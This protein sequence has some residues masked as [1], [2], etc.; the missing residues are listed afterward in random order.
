[1]TEV[2][3]R[4]ALVTGASGDI[5]A[6]CALELAA[7][8][9]V[10]AVGYGGRRDAAEAT[11]SQI[12]EQGGTALAVQ[13]DVSDP[14]GVEAGF[15]AVESAYGPVELLV[16]AAGVNRDKL[17]LQLKDEDWLHTLDTNLSGAFRVTRRALRP[18]VRNRFG[19]IVTMSSV[20][21]AMGGPGQ[22]NYA[23]SKAGLVG[24]ARS[25][26]R[27]VASRNITLNVV[28]PGPISTAMLD[29]LSDDRR[30]QLAEATPVGRVG[31]PREVAALV[32]FLCSDAA[33][34]ITGALIPVDGGL[35]MGR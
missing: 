29:E 32:A 15:K 11:V 5:G 8:G 1:M 4:V 19:R 3:K 7:A 14:D 6:A 35:S 10:V 27:E 16:N 12:D 30:R 28:E 23:A 2:T 13:V 34:Y 26:A 21:A 33:S 24:L 18:M 17:M 25:T 20:V 9:H 31:E 22:A